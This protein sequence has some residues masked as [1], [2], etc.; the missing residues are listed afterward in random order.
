DDDG[1]EAISPEGIYYKQVA[2]LPSDWNEQKGVSLP[3]PAK[4]SPLKKMQVGIVKE[5]SLLKTFY[6]V[7]FNGKWYLLYMYDCGA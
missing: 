1:L 4:F 5:N 6:F 3:V 2:K 7:E